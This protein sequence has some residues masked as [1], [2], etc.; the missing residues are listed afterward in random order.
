MRK[1]KSYNVLMNNI[2]LVL[3]NKINRNHQQMKES[4]IL[5]N[6]IMI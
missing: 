1:S 6:L 3:S 5:N 4:Q 2:F